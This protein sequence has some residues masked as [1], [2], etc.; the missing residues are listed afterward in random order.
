[1][2]EERAI[3]QKEFSLEVQRPVREI[4]KEFPV[5]FRTYWNIQIADP[6][7]KALAL[8]LFYV[9]KAIDQNSPQPFANDAYCARRLRWHIRT[10]AKYREVLEK[11][12]AVKHIKKRRKNYIRV[13]YMVGKI[14]G[15]SINLNTDNIAEALMGTYIVFD[16]YT[17]WINNIKSFKRFTRFEKQV[18]KRLGYAPHEQDIADRL[19]RAWDKI[20]S[21]GWAIV[22]VNNELS[23]EQYLA[24]SVANKFKEGN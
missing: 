19:E 20:C 5:T 17:V 24:E 12:G 7:G 10:V 18:A 3:Y 22:K 8:Y 23:F 6:S 1:M 15:P 2:I 16:Y 9:Q 11:C 21:E 4:G 13:N 14:T